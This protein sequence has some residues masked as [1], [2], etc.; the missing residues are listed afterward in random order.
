MAGAGG[1]WTGVLAIAV[2]LLGAA[3]VSS[4]QSIQKG[5]VGILTGKLTDLH[6]N[7]LP[8]VAVILRNQATGAEVSTTTANN[9]V[10]RFRELKPG[11]YSLEARSPQLGHGRLNEIVVSAGHEAR[12]Q[13]AMEFEL[14][15]PRSPILAASHQTGSGTPRVS[16]DRACPALRPT[17]RGCRRSAAPGVRRSSAPRA[18]DA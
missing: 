10:Y 3:R 18:S 1:N 8:G 12:V 17:H 15:H 9:G 5:S 7:P 13:A 4:A 2:L 11:E 16:P 14:P 6:S